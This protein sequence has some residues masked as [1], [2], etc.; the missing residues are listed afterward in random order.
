[1]YTGPDDPTAGTTRLVMPPKSATPSPGRALAVAAMSATVFTLDSSLNIIALP[2]IAE[3]FDAAP[4]EVIWVSVTVQL[5]ILGLTLPVGALSAS[6][7]RRRLFTLGFGVFLAGLLGAFLAPT[8]PSLVAARAVQ[9]AGIGLFISTRN[10][11]AAEGF[12]PARRGFVMGVIIACVGLGSTLGP[13]LGGALIDATSWR[14]IYLAELPLALTCGVAALL[15]L[16]WE[17]RQRLEVFDLAGALLIF[18]GLAAL[19]LGLNRLASWGATS[20]ALLGLALGSMALVGLFLWHERRTA[21]PV[22]D[23]TLLR[24]RSVWAPSLV[25][26]LQVAGN[27]AAVLVL[28]FFLLQAL[29]LQATAAGALYAVSPAA[30]FLGGVAGGPLSD[31]LGVWTIFRGSMA[32]IVAGALLLTT[33]NETTSTLLVALSLV[34]LGGGAGTLQAASGS[35]LLNAVPVRRL[36][37]A[38]ALFIAII[39]LAGA[40]GGTLGGTLIT[41]GPLWAG[42]GAGQRAAVATAYH[43]VA[44]AAAL[45]FIAG[46]AA[47]LLPAPIGPDC[48]RGEKAA[49]D[50]TLSPEATPKP[51]PPM[52]PSP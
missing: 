28:P 11:I 40:V 49:P 14:A 8:L 18:G 41:A 25:L 38:S 6:L 50:E 10:A 42:T 9:G 5:V 47:S 27:A 3:S 34:L 44:V 35:A 31:R 15:F 19:L 30:M 17:R 29:G 1:M 39:M 21:Q 4:A 36:G 37:M 32:A 2:A 16:P 20:P 33:M 7:G 46:L 45:I 51:S 23:L 26:A 12:P 22:L 43:P 48:G 24:Q 52:S 13:L